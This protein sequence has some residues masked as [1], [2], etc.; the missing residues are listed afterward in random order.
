LNAA[1]A[2]AYYL[3]LPYLLFFKDTNPVADP[4]NTSIS[5]KVLSGVLGVIVLLLFFNPDLLMQWISAF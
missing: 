4:P 5:G 3:R 2:L 1:V